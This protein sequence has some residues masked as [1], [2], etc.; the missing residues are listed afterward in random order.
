ML[1]SRP[2]RT[3]AATLS[4]SAG[5]RLSLSPSRRR[6]CFESL[7]RGLNRAR[8]LGST[9]M[10]LT[11]ISDR[12]R[13][14]RDVSWRAVLGTDGP[15]SSLQGG[16]GPRPG[17]SRISESAREGRV[18]FLRLDEFVGAP[19]HVRWRTHLARWRDRLVRQ[20]HRSRSPLSVLQS[21]AC[22]AQDRHLQAPRSPPVIG[23]SASDR[24]ASARALHQ[25]AARARPVRHARPPGS[26]VTGAGPLA[27][28]SRARRPG[29]T[30][31][32]RP[33]VGCGLRSGARPRRARVKG[34]GRSHPRRA[35]RGASAAKRRW[36]RYGCPWVQLST[37]SSSS[38]AAAPPR[39][40]RKPWASALVK[41]SSATARPTLK[42]VR[43]ASRAS[44]PGLATP[45]RQ[46]VRRR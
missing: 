24:A 32:R 36:L 13:C 27:P 35:P 22:C 39:A 21:A 40:G 7:A 46:K 30:A 14:N 37:R 28:R 26:P 6:T 10:G 8:G 23:R 42:G 4:K 43:T 41:S 34:K 2:L 12:A 11:A 29:Q 19:R 25:T 3:S 5:D 17:L 44:S 45:S 33:A 18:S 20:Q 15:E 1:S 16:D 9:V 38:P 31:R